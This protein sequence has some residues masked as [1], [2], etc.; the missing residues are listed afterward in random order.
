MLRLKIFALTILIALSTFSSLNV[1]FAR[2]TPNPNKKCCYALI[3]CASITLHSFKADAAY[4]YHVLRHHYIFDE[5]YYLHVLTDVE[6]VN[7]SAT[8]DNVRLAINT[9]LASWSD[10][11]DVVFIFFTGH[12]G[13][14]D[15]HDKAMEGG[16]IDGSMGDPLDEGSE[17]WNDTSEEWI[18]V[19]ECL[20]THYDKYWDDEFKEDLNSLT[21]GRL[22]IAVLA[23]YSGGL[24]DD[25]TGVNRIIMTAANETHTCAGDLYAEEGGWPPLLSDMYNEWP[26]V[27][28]DALHGE[29]TYF[30]PETN[31]V[32][33]KNIMV[34][35]DSDNDGNVSM[36][37]AWQ[38]AWNH[39]D[40]RIY[41]DETPWLDDNNNALPTYIN[42]SDVGSPCDDGELA[43]TVWFPRKYYNLTVRTY[44]TSGSE[45]NSMVKVWVDGDFSGK[46]PTTVNV[47]AEYHD[48]QV[49]SPIYWGD[50]EYKFSFWEDS[51]TTNPRMVHIHDDKTIKAYYKIQAQGCPFVSTWNGTDFVIDNNLLAN[52]AR[53]GGTEVEDYYKLEQSL[54][55]I[56]EWN[57][58]SL[59]PLLISEFQQEHSYLDQTQFIAVDHDADVKVA[60]SPFGEILTYQNP[61]APVSAVDDQGQ[62][63]IELIQDIDDAY[64]EGYNGSYLL[65]S[66]GEV[67]AE[68]AKLVMRADRPPLKE[69]VHIQVLNS[70]ENW[71]DVASIIPR[72]Y[73]ATEIIDLSGYLPSTGEFKVRLYF[74]DKH[75]VDFVG[76]DTTTQTE[77][78]VEEAVL[79]LAYHSDDGD[80]TTKLQ[81]D[82]DVYAELVPEQQITLLFAATTQG[83]EQRTFIIYVKGYYI[84]IDN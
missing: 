77:I 49:E 58:Q 53:S 7:A 39:S 76:L 25:L 24:I 32:V 47:T 22:V 30:N 71:V 50:Y 81:A 36:L 34:D 1:W 14:Y 61:Y 3:I 33:H 28:I 79:L 27:F 64:Y 63:H 11:N 66:F 78:D 65:L 16:R 38:Y 54:V 9:T 60:V 80:V 2:A 83:G 42:G 35:A 84:T 45:I 82:D 46:S 56:G 19:D 41:G 67:T 10:E 74:T 72:T 73:W 59:Y 8:K 55:P 26:E 40:G 62:D 4:M 70:T 37:E 23:C 21:Y 68:N 48:V 20:Y 17:I 75:K 6:G 51:S 57:D 52:S 12:G 44:T 69:S 15:H 18:G 29:D 13:G 43:A 31:E 5:I